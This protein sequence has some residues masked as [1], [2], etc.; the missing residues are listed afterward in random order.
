MIKEQLF[1]MVSNST[2]DYPT[3]KHKASGKIPKC[4][5]IP[6]KATGEKEKHFFLPSRKL[7]ANSAK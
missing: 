1:V 2:K 5:L 6:A 7:K 4:Y 3:K